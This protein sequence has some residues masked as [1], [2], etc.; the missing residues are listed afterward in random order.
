M[1]FG[2]KTVGEKTGGEKTGGEKTD[3]P[4][5]KLSMKGSFGELR[6]NR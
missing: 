3:V 2:E 1:S 4:T 6:L 5:L